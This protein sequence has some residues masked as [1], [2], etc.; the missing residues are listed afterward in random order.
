MRYFSYSE[1]VGE[2]G[3]TDK[4]VTMSEEEIRKDYYPW[5]YERMCKKYGQEHV[6]A[7]YS[8]EECL[9]D[10]LIVNGACGAWEI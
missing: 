8:F 10:W 6:D 2:Q 3:W 7:I 4:I 5:W 1:P 9:E